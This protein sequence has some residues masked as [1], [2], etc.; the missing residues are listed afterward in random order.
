M[1]AMQS[2]N[3]MRAILVACAVFAAIVAA[4]FG[5]WTVAAVL[6]VAVAA[7]GAMWVYIYR[8]GTHP[9]VRREPA[10]PA[11]RR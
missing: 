11:Q 8:R 4:A 10:E 2:L 6:T 5:M 3:T 1:G 7:H 9:T